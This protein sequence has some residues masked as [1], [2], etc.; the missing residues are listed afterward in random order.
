MD[1]QA[2]NYDRPQRFDPRGLGAPNLR[3]VLKRKRRADDV[4]PD[5]IAAL[6]RRL[7]IAQNR[8]AGIGKKG[9]QEIRSGGE[10]AAILRMRR[11]Q[12][13]G[14]GHPQD[15]QAALQHMHRDQSL[16]PGHHGRAPYQ[17]PGR[18]VVRAPQVP[19]AVVEAMMGPGQRVAMGAPPLHPRDELKRRIRRNVRQVRL[20]GQ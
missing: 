9:L 1:P 13:L 16:L 3:R 19:P 2:V 17:D 18:P 7:S 14:L 5:L 6:K 12:A 15:K 10:D 4:D 8:T 20:P 11:D